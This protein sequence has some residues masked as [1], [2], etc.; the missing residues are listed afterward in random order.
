V[1]SAD[2]L[3]F[4]KRTHTK[5]T[6][7]LVYVD[8]IILTGNDDK[9]IS[10]ITKLLDQQFIIK[11]LG[12]LTY[13]LGLKVARNKSGLH[14]SQRKY[15]LDLLHATRMLD[16]ACMPHSSRISS[17]NIQLNEEKSSTYCKLIGR[18]IYFTSTRPDIAYSVYN[19]IQFVSSPT[20]HHQQVVFRILRYLKGNSGSRIFLHRTVPT[21]FE[22]T[23]ILIGPHVLKLDN[24]LLASPFSWVSV[25]YHGSP[26]N[27]RLSQ[28]VLRKPS[29]EPLQQPLGKFSG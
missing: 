16:C 4:L 7:L 6:A 22:V 12:D 8:D 10:H 23:V 13:F 27:N 20:K 15:T 18:L 1:S 24:S 5:L 3:L 28:E 19:L 2:H 29:I 17:T 11:N 14:I 26:R 9:E 21:S 25:L